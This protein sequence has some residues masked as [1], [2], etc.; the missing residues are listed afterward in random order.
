MEKY[1]ECVGGASNEN[2]QRQYRP[3]RADGNGEAPIPA[4][5]HQIVEEEC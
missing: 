2:E 4:E 5:K 3:R 1:R